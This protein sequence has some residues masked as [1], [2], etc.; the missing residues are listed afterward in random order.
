[1]ALINR[2]FKWFLMLLLEVGLKAGKKAYDLDQ[3]KREVNRDLKSI[4]QESAT[5][6]VEYK[7]LVF[8]ALTSDLLSEEEVNEIL[9]HAARDFVSVSSGMRDRP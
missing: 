9:I 1:M 4:D 6:L 2:F 3:D 8:D 5:G 7:S